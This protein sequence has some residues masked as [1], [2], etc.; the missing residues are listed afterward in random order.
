MAGARTPRLQRSP[1][2][3]SEMTDRKTDTHKQRE[4]NEHKDWLLGTDANYNSVRTDD[5]QSH[6]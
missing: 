6:F 2:A 3:K 1:A 5:W 4:F